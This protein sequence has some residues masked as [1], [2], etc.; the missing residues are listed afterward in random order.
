[1]SRRLV[2][3]CLQVSGSVLLAVAG[4]FVSPALGAAI[5]GVAAVVFGVA[6]ERDG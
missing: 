2:A 3:A 4:W 5:A 1:M 6:V